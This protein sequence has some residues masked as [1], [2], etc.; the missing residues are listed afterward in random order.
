MRARF[1]EERE[2]SERQH[3]KALTERLE[4]ERE[5]LLREAKS[6]V[7]TTHKRELAECEAKMRKRATQREAKVTQELSERISELEGKLMSRRKALAIRDSGTQTEEEE[8]RGMKGSP[9]VRMK[10]AFISSMSHV[11]ASQNEC[12]KLFSSALQLELDKILLTINDNFRPS[13]SGMSTLFLGSINEK[14]GSLVEEIGG[15]A[16]ISEIKDKFHLI[17][18]RVLS[19]CEKQKTERRAL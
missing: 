5:R 18:Q 19:V 16:H 11:P 12:L 13:E 17:L 4:G 15:E 1:K 7:E 14:I 6:E 3:A 10:R 2:R 9:E 8:V